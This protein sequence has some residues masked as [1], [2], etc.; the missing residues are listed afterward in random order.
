M[1]RVSIS[2]KGMFIPEKGEIFFAEVPNKGIDR[3]VK[4]M[5]SKDKNQC[6]NCVFCRGELGLLCWNVRCSGNLDGEEQLTFR[7]VSDGKI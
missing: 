6:E 4:A 3:K 7:R 2:D 5:V 1:R